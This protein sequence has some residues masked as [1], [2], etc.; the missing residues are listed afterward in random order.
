MLSRWLPLL[1]CL[2]FAICCAI[3]SCVPQ[4]IP[5]PAGDTDERRGIECPGAL[6]PCPCEAPLVC[7]P[8]DACAAPCSSDQDCGPL[9]GNGCLGGL[10]GVSCTPGGFDDC[11]AVGMIGSVCLEIQGVAVCGYTPA[12]VAPSAD[13]T[14]AA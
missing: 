1:L 4:P 6:C 8:N 12:V 7:A 14:G 5:V 11:S 10:C 2:P 3:L 13:S 9:S